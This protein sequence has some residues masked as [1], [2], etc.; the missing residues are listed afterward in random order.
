MERKQRL[1]KLRGRERWR[2]AGLFINTLFLRASTL[3]ILFYIQARY[4][5]IPTID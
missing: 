2:G 5:F 3:R 1:Y 4:C